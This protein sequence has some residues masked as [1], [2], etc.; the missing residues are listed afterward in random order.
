[1]ATF[2]SEEVNLTW[3]ESFPLPDRPNEYLF[4]VE[5]DG[6]QQTPHVG[7]AIEKLRTQAL[8][9]DVLGAYPRG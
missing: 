2:Q 7:A 6:H 1:M 4:F 9:L 5:L 3:I 8:R